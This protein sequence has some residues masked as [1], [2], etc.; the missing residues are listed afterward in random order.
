MG[1]IV[2]LVGV[3]VVATTVVWLIRRFP[4]VRRP[5]AWLW[6]ALERRIFALC[7]AVSRTTDF[8]LAAGSDDRSP[9]WRTALWIAAALLPL[10]LFFA[11]VVARVPAPGGL[12]PGYLLILG[13]AFAVFVLGAGFLTV[14]EDYDV[15]NGGVVV[16]ARRFGGARAVT[17][18]PVV[19]LSF[20][21]FAAYVVTIGWWLSDLDGVALAVRQPQTGL[22][23]LD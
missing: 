4:S 2:A 16:D 9:Q 5:V 1:T 8:L 3:V 21:L 22:V 13:A 19:A 23:P 17:R 7:G 12:D 6:R 14:Y 20:V 15:M 18:P 11:A 10:A